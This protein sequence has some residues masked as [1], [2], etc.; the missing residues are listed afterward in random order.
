MKKI[1]KL[2]FNPRTLDEEIVKDSLEAV[3]QLE[4][5]ESLYLV[6][7]MGIQSYFPTLLR[8]P[9]S[10]LDYS[11]VRPLGYPDFREMIKP[12]QEFL[13]DKKYSVQT[14]KGSSASMLFVYDSKTEDGLAVEFARRNKNNFEKR[15]NILQRELE[16]SKS[17]I[18]EGRTKTYRVACPED[19]AIP[20]LVRLI[21]SLDRTP[22]LEAL[23]PDSL[24]SLSNEDI[25]KTLKKI[26][27]LREET[28][29]S[30]GDVGLA[31]KLRF[32]SDLYDV[33]ALAE[34][35]GFNDDYFNKIEKEW[36]SIDSKPEIRERIFDVTL[37]G[38]N[39]K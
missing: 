23:L 11:L 6:G 1:K 8:R 29:I 26:A 37:P 25:K 5:N 28:M 35:T 27:N 19:L 36:L 22:E 33:R 24:K 31:E 18:I 20:K 38:R 12:V 21:N 2:T 10:D 17:K 3:S 7:G 30:S 15:Q 16:N 34:I 13:Q 4:K 9:T 32:I 14:R 39:S